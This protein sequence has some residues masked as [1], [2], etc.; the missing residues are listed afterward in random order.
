MESIHTESEN[1]SEDFDNIDLWASIISSLPVASRKARTWETFC[2]QDFSEPTIF[3]SE[4][5]EAVWS[6]VWKR[7]EPAGSVNKVAIR[8]DWVVQS[9][10]DL[11]L[12]LESAV[13][14]FD[15]VGQP[16]ARN[17]VT[18][19]GLSRNLTTD[20]VKA[21][22]SCGESFRAIKSFV[23]KI[24]SNSR[25]L[26]SFT[27]ASSALGQITNIVRQYILEQSFEV[28][29]VLQ[30]QA[31]FQL[32]TILLSK[33]RIAIE[34]MATCRDDVAVINCAIELAEA[35]EAVDEWYYPLVLQILVL[36]TKPFLEQISRGIGLLSADYSEN[37]LLDG[38]LGLETSFTDATNESK[39]SGL[40]DE[41]QGRNIFM[42]HQSLKLLR[43]HQPEHTL[44]HPEQLWHVSSAGLELATAW[45]DIDRLRKRVGNLAANMDISSSENVSDIIP[46]PGQ[47]AE[48]LELDFDPYSSDAG[49]LLQKIVHSAS[50]LNSIDTFQDGRQMDRLSQVAYDVLHTGFNAYSHS[51]LHAPLQ[52]LKFESFTRL[53]LVQS[54]AV[55]QACLDM[56]FKDHDLS[57]NLD[58]LYEFHL[59]GSG[60][61]ATKLKEALF[62]ANLSSTERKK[63]YH[64]TGQ[65]GLRLGLRSTWPPASAELRLALMGILGECHRASFRHTNRESSDDLPGG[66]AFAIRNLSEPEIEACMNPQSLA[67]L[68]FLRLQYQPPRALGSVITESALE[69][70]DH[71]FRFLLRLSRVSFAVDQMWL[72]R[73]NSQDSPDDAMTRYTHEVHHFISELTSYVHTSTAITW[74]RFR[75]I[76]TTIETQL[77]KPHNSTTTNLFQLSALHDL[78]LD[79]ITS[80]LLLR[81]RHEKAKQSLDQILTSILQLASAPDSPQAQT[82][83]F[84][85]RSQ[86]KL[87]IATCRHF[88]ERGNHGQPQANPLLSAE[89]GMAW[90]AGASLVDGLQSLLLGLDF[91]GIYSTK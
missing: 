81:H 27:A 47:I 71:I 41:V 52:I 59:L 42:I 91:N 37:A 32:P 76:L 28:V 36:I 67:A 30:L 61:F 4:G 68:D 51:V 5:S 26:Q 15:V 73:R 62:S 33:L 29:T 58:V 14:T 63:G 18:F 22:G 45:D 7:F 48:M 10:I 6:A 13:F 12:G 8:R 19:S 75:R 25:S 3:L 38:L 74:T 20:V 46:R 50:M 55:N 34:T 24:R 78:M 90:N 21:I 60:I 44:L 23:K 86:V 82:A 1:D 79:T 87:F 64:R 17:D 16:H 53:I 11:G 9:L 56:V 49:L 40:F 65:L 80:N 2:D 77:D 70:Y 39:L 84:S 35:H 83:F 57:Y 43:V 89:L 66:L 31:L 85:F 72:E 69:K 88:V 54:Q